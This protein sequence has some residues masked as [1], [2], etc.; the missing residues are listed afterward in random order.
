MQGFHKYNPDFQPGEGQHYPDT[1]KKPNHPTF[2][3][4]SIYHGGKYE[5]GQWQKNEDGSYQ[6]TPG[7]TNL[8]HYTPQELQDYFNKVEPG[9]KLNLP[10]SKLEEPKDIHI[11]RHGTTEEN[12]EDKIRGT[13]DD[14]KLSDEG[15]KHALDAAEELRGKGLEALVSSP[16]ARAKETS[17]IIGKELGIPITVSDK[18]KTWNVGDFEGKPCEGNN[19][20][21]QNYAEKKPDEVVPGGESYNQFKD[22][23][24]EGIREAIL[25]NKDKKLGIVTHHMVESSLEGWEKTGQ[26]NP[27]LDLSKLFEDTDQPGSVRKMTMQPDSTIMQGSSDARMAQEAREKAAGRSKQ[28]VAPEAGRQEGAISEW[29]QSHGEKIKTA[30][31]D[32]LK[33][34][35]MLPSTQEGMFVAP[36]LGRKLFAQGLLKQ[37]LSPGEVKAMT[38]VERGAEG[39]LREEISDL[40]SRIKA[41]PDPYG[42]YRLSQ[43]FNHPELYKIY[44]ELKDVDIY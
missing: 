25:A 2:S 34:P 29:I 9:N 23:A 5:G 30:L 4:E 14:V 39:I 10:Q 43:I 26:D 41:I 3:N 15:R 36:S 31:E 40:P 22:R 18:L 42:K 17:Q 20:T 6:F 33:H 16:L 44:P 11:I 7:R 38:G 1:F 28:A 8:E 13:N 24:F 12:E 37:G 32:M 21:L 27:S 19:N 35:E